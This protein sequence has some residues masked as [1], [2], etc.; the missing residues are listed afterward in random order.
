MRGGIVINS[1]RF[2]PLIG[3]VVT[4]VAASSCCILPLFLGA[5]SAGTIGLS[6]ALAPYRPYFIALT[7]LMI[8]SAFYATYRSREADCCTA[9]T[10]NPTRQVN[11]MILWGV[12]ILTLASLVYPNFAAIRARQ[13]A[14]APRTIIAPTGITAVFA[15][16]NMSCVECTPSI[17]KNLRDAPGVYDA[18]VNFPT[19]Q[20]TVRFDPALMDERKLRAIIVKTGFIVQ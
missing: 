7:V 20:A 11:K 13:V 3:G 1:P 4:A 14:R 2:L 10:P 6:A 17:V 15:I 18:A 8:G 9:T 16:G 12:A 5:A 19:K